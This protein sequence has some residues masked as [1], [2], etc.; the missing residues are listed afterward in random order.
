MTSDMKKTMTLAFPLKNRLGDLACFALIF[1]VFP[2]AFVIRGSTSRLVALL[3]LIPIVGLFSKTIRRSFVYCWKTYKTWI[4]ALCIFPLVILLR[5][6]LD[7]AIK[8]INVDGVSRFILAIPLFVL[9]SQLKID[10]I[11]KVKWSWLCAV[12]VMLSAG[13]LFMYW[14][15]ETRIRTYYVNTLP[16]SVFALVFGTLLLISCRDGS[17]WEKGLSWAGF[18]CSL[19][20]VF[21][22]QGR[23]TWLAVPFAFYFY[24]ADARTPARKRAFWPLMGILAVLAVLSY[25]TSHTISSRIDGIFHDINCYFNG[26][27]DTSVG[28]RLDMYKA[29]LYLFADSPF[30]GAGRDIHDALLGLYHR[31]V[32]AQGT[33]VFGDTH[34]EFFYTMASL[35][36]AGIIAFVIFYLF[37]T[38]PFWRVRKDPDPEIAKVGQMGTSVNAIF[39]VAG[40]TNV[41]LNLVM[42]VSLYALIQALLLA[43][44]DKLRNG[45]VVS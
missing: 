45:E 21:L 19:V 1:S 22:S 44:L 14:T 25:F 26:M 9:V 17:G 20:I 43:W 28:Y 5:E 33:T 8:T 35:G 37:G 13:L 15:G 3:A 24:L 6:G 42:Y 36:G 32:I 7:P 23:G 34:S 11:R 30:L 40:L 10:L 18:L 16:F 38:R 39:L 29:S 2:L 4:L 31:G 27:P 41:T 12:V